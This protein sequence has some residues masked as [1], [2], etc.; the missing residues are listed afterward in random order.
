MSFDFKNASKAELTSKY[1]EI[2]K[3]IGDARFSTRKELDYLP[4]VL[5]DG[6]QILVFASG[7]MDS[8]T[9]L[10]AVTDRRVLFLDKGMFWGLKQTSIDLSR[11]NSVSGE[12][13]IVFGKITIADGA[14]NYTITMVSKTSVKPVTNKINEYLERRR[15]GNTIQPSGGGTVDELERLAALREKGLLT[16]EEFQT[17]KAKILAG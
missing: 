3:E 2:A 16:D 10:I 14:Q 4:E 13:G 9:W 17:E 11:V 8:N 5:L 1:N 6:E 15:A 7:M 12:T